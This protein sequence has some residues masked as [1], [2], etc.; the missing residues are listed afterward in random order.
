[1]ITISGLGKSFP[2]RD[3]V[4]SEVDLH[5]GDTGLVLLLGESGAGKTTLLNIL[6]GQLGF[7]NGEINWNGNVLQGLVPPELAAETEYL[8]QAPFFADFLS[9]RD[10]LR[11]LGRDDARTE[12]ELA[13]LGLEQKAEQLPPTLSGGERQRLSFVRSCLKDKRILLLDEPT[14]SLD[15]ENKRRLFA[16]LRELAGDRLLICASHDPVALDY[17][18]EVVRFDKETGRLTQE[19]LR[20]VPCENAAGFAEEERRQ[21]PAEERERT[22]PPAGGFL[23]KWLAS[24]RERGMRLR[25]TL[26]LT[27]ALALCALADTPEHKNEAT[28][29]HMYRMNVLHLQVNGNYEAEDLLPEDS[30]LREKLI[31]YNSSVPMPMIS[32]G[33]GVLSMP[34]YVTNLA[35]VPKEKARFALAG[36]IAYGE[37]PGAANEVLITKAMAESLYPGKPERV[38]GQTISRRLYG[39]GELKL[40]VVG[41]LGELSDAERIY[42]NSLGAQLVIGEPEAGGF[43]QV[44]WLVSAETLTPLAA[45]PSFYSES[46]GRQRVWYLIFENYGEMD[47]YFR[48]HEVL[49]NRDLDQEGGRVLLKQQGIP[50]DYELDWPLYSGV[51]LSL[52]ALMM[53]LTVLFYTGLKRTELAYDSRFLAVF[54]YAGYE[55]RKLLRK[56]IAL[57]LRELAGQLL[58]AFAFSLALTAGGNLLNES[59]HI[60]PVMLFSYNPRILGGF[61]A[62]VLLFGWLFLRSA[63]RRVEVKS[64][65]ELL[66]ETQDLL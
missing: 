53:L 62:A 30:R 18:D 21:P 4:L 57:S 52:S 15:G 13:R 58:I 19:R 3:A 38:I 51:L 65:Y 59:R 55:K 20:E 16:L 61:A 42:L 23:R 25:F 29:S 24:S 27:V 39:L 66:R 1:M 28:M 9:V 35:V 54:A 14:A 5:F 8:T 56:L 11:L 45:D 12:A 22:L 40:T 6:A 46:G 63:Y 2:G 64:W 47:A 10:N 26:F 32:A 31:N 41:I 17:A 7:D 34:N 48:D 44:T 33:N 60:L 43:E 37:Y 50:L 36:R 49:L